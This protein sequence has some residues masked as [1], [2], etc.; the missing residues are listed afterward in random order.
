[1]YFFN[2][3]KDILGKSGIF[4]HYNLTGDTNG[5]FLKRNP[6]S[7]FAIYMA[8]PHKRNLGL[9]LGLWCLTPLS[10]IFQL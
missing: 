5:S 6:V 2:G 8:F 3:I 7:M 10:T 9:C 4:K 1:M